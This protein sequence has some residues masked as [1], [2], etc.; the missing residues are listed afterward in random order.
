MINGVRQGDVLS[1]QLFAVYIDNL[2][3]RLNQGNTRC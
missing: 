3:A 1:P 2:S